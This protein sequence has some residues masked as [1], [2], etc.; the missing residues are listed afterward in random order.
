MPLFAASSHDRSTSRSV[1]SRVARRLI[2]LARPVPTLPTPRGFAQAHFPP[3]VLEHESKYGFS[4]G[5]YVLSPG[6]APVYGSVEVEVGR[7]WYALMMLARPQ[8]VLE[9][10]TH[11]GYSTCC[12]AA[13]LR[14]LSAVD[15]KPRELITIDPAPMPH[16][17]EGTDLAPFI[18]WVPKLSFDVAKEWETSGT[19]QS[20]D[21]LV[22][23]SD[24]HYDTIIF[25]LM[26]FE[27]M[28][29]AGG[30]LL[31]H[32]TLYFDGV[33]AAVRQLRENPRFDCVTLPTPRVHDNPPRRCP[34]I[35][36]AHKHHE[37][38]PRLQFEE[39]YRGWNDGATSTEPYLWK[40]TRERFA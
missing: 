34:G 9:T 37:G 21:A 33:G 27:P 35:T 3:S 29:R 19:R 1:F 4:H 6:A 10:G 30:M 23:D 26:A 11:F 20:F 24:H 25:E 18:R 8:R 28:L 22:L 5:G 36:I 39:R 2:N 15:G 14:D 40:R 31:L 12:I 38:E 17:W 13:A 32:D 16:L 7:T